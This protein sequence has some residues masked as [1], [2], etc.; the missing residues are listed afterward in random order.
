MPKADWRTE[1]K[2]FWTDLVPPQGQANTVQGELVRAVAKLKDEAYRNGNQNFGANH[3]IPCKYVR[4]TMAD[5]EVFD[6]EEIRSINSSID[7]VLDA[8][9]PDV[10]GQATCFSSVSRLASS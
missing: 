1:F 7:G 6:D 3:R 2:R 10:M 9:F 4:E 8:E 5:T